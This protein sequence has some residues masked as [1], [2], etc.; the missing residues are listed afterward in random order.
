MGD[1]VEERA[2]HDDTHKRLI[3]EDQP[4]LSRPETE[5]VVDQA[6]ECPF[7]AGQHKE[8]QRSH[9]QQGAQ[10]RHVLQQGEIEKL[11]V[12]L[13]CTRGGSAAGQSEPDPE[14]SDS[15]SACRR[16]AHQG[17][18][19]LCGQPATESRTEDQAGSRRR[20]DPSHRCRST[21]FVCGIG[22]I[23]LRHYDV[24][25]AEACQNTARQYS[26]N[27]M[28][29]RVRQHRACR[30]QAADNNNRLAACPVAQLSPD[31]REKQSVPESKRQTRRRSASRVRHGF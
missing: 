28:R 12:R 13:V 19:S 27:A 26:P 5:I 10:G 30:Q 15:R 11:L 18:A 14:D 1:P 29:Q 31:R 24:R 25:A 21:L 23:G 4:E 7:Q 17:I 8:R 2:L 6:S 22:E 16:P 9:H 20:S 3:A